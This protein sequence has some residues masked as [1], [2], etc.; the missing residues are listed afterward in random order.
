MKLAAFF[1]CIILA[2]CESS[3]E[4]KLIPKEKFTTIHGEI[5]TL[6]AY[7]QLN[8]R[9]VGVYKDSLKKSVDD[10]LEKHGFTFKQYEDTY[11]YYAIRQE[12]FQEINK[13][14]I[15]RFNAEKL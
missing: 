13:D 2:A 7:Y 1:L 10:L 9:S 4:A 6:E 15:E 5:L 12:K 8:Y 11:N 14:L 3:E